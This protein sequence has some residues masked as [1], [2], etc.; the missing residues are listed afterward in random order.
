MENNPGWVMTGGS[1]RHVRMDSIIVKLQN[2]S[3][4]TLPDMEYSWAEAVEAGI[5]QNTIIVLKT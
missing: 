2:I 1:A 3:S 4:T 5:V